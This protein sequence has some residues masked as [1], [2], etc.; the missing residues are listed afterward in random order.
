[1]SIPVVNARRT[2]ATVW[3]CGAFFLFGI[4]LLQTVLGKYGARYDEVWGWLLP[5]VVPTLSLITGVFVA[6]AR[7]KPD[8]STT[9]DRYVHRL[10]LG[11]SLTYLL[12]VAMTILL[13]PF[14]HLYGNITP[15]ELLRNSNLWLG[16]F[17]GLVTAALG[18][19]FVRVEIGAKHE[20][21]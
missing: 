2:L 20:Q 10:S 5:T 9:V 13:S 11:L 15:L 1:M 21:E 14:A 7:T 18:A 6:T 16:P 8:H 4:V 19:I 12:V 3:F 17:Q